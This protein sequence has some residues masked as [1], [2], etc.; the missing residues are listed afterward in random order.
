MSFH[1]WNLP[2][3]IFMVYAVSQAHQFGLSPPKVFNTQFLPPLT[4]FLDEALRRDIGHQHGP[5]L[6]PSL[7]L[8]F[9]KKWPEHCYMY[10]RLCNWKRA[11]LS[12]VHI[13]TGNVDRQKPLI[14][15]LLNLILWWA[16]TRVAWEH[17]YS[18]CFVALASLVP[19]LLPMHLDE[20]N[21]T[22]W[23]QSRLL[24]AQENV[25]EYHY[26]WELG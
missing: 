15:I 18:A 22:I 1:G 12:T 11:T 16:S 8:L 3:H 21:N 19:R 13:K 5:S 10:Y 14:H 24:S 7:H 2:S 20:W 25:C 4:K 9:I 26:F 23:M 17:S 6:K